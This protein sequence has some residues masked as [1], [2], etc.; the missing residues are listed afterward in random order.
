MPEDALTVD[1]PSPSL[2]D[3]L[4]APVRALLHEIAKFG[5]VGGIAFVIDVGLFNVLLYGGVLTDRPITSKIVSVAVATTFAYFANRYWTFRHRGRTHMGREYLL[6]FLLNGAAM[7]ISVSCLYVSHY[8]LGLDSALADN[9]SANVVG[10]AL[11]TLFRFWSYRRWVFPA[12]PDEVTDGASDGVSDRVADGVS[13]SV[14]DGVS[15]SVADGAHEEATDT[16]DRAEHLADRR[17]EPLTD[18]QAEHLA[19]RELAERDASTPI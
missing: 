8:I 3:R 12:L 11:G 13:D 7:V 5:I 9:I 4:Y 14:A 6:F 15:D 16:P 17:A 1:A 10:V 2:V 19:D 18:R